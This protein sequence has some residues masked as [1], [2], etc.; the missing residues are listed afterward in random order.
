[1]NEGKKR[2]KYNKYNKYNKY[3]PVLLWDSYGGYS[4]VRRGGVQARRV[5]EKG[6]GGIAV[7]T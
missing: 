5:Q 7:A 3:P 4:C 6:G 2:E 1:M